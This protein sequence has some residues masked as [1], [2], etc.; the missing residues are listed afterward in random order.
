VEWQFALIII[1][2]FII[3]TDVQIKVTLNIITVLWDTLHKLQLK[4]YRTV[5]IRSHEEE[6]SGVP[7][8]MS[9]SPLLCMSANNASVECLSQSHEPVRMVLNN[10]L[11]KL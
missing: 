7:R 10:S 2:I 4:L 11:L 5:T 8:W 9:I 3:I 1:I 6:L